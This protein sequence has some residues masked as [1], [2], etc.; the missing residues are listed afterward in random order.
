MSAGA[1]L[2]TWSK[3]ADPRIAGQNQPTLDIDLDPAK[4]SGTLHGRF[5]LMPKSGSGTWEGELTGQIEKGLVVASGIAAG[6]GDLSGE[7]LRVDFRQVEKLATPPPCPD[8]KAFF[9]MRGLILR[10]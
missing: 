5:T 6:T 9:E 3:S 8:P 10:R 7:A 2:P 1:S 4:G